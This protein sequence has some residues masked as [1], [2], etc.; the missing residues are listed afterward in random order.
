M[1][2]KKILFSNKERAQEVAQS[3]NLITDAFL[4]TKQEAQPI[5]AGYFQTMP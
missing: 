3:M 5:I 2:Y 4:I 1:N